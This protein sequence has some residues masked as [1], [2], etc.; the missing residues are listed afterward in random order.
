MSLGKGEKSC[1]LGLKA[2]LTTQLTSTAQPL[3]QSSKSKVVIS[4]YKSMIH[5]RRRREESCYSSESEEEGE[6]ESDVE[7]TLLC[8]D[9]SVDRF[10]RVLEESGIARPVAVEMD[11][12]GYLRSV[13]TG[14]YLVDDTGNGF[15]FS[16]AELDYLL[17]RRIVRM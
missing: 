13:E 16:H 1:R 5:N 4:K 6:V 11:Q 8:E 15:E 9:S 3:L 10:L 7:I 14:M 17:S 12:T 2:S